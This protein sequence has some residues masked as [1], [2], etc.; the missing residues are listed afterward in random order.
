MTKTCPNGHRMREL[1]TRC[2][3][4]GW[5][6]SSAE[7]RRYSN[8]QCAYESNGDRCT[9]PGTI[10]EDTKASEGSRWYCGE[11]YATLGSPAMAQQVLYAMQSGK[12]R[13]K[14]ISW[15]EELMQERLEAMRKTNPEMFFHPKN[16]QERD[17]YQAMVMNYIRTVKFTAKPL[18]YD[19]RKVQDDVIPDESTL[20]TG[21]EIAA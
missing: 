3:A 15:S 16:Q 8:H 11:H 17:D 4:C 1:Q 12:I 18:P 7:T 14:K 13:L 19:K 20:L 9:F 2:A 6:E 10:T 21:R 5:S